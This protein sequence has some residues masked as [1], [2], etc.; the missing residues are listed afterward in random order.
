MMT[1]AKITD[2]ELWVTGQLM[3]VIADT[4]GGFCADTEL[5]MLDIG[6]VHFQ[7][8]ILSISCVGLILHRNW[9]VI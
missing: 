7:G 2:I 6:M 4:D 5:P 9:G 1:L 3:C 8:W